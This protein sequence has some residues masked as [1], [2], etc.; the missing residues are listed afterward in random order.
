MPCILSIFWEHCSSFRG[1]FH[2]KQ[3]NPGSGNQSWPPRLP[4]DGDGF[5]FKS[6]FIDIIR[7]GVVWFNPVEIKGPTFYCSQFLLC[8]R[9]ASP[10]GPSRVWI[11]MNAPKSSCLDTWSPVGGLGGMVLLKEVCHCRCAL[12][13][14]KD[15]FH[16]QLT[17]C[18]LLLN[19]DV[20][21]QLFHLP[22]LC[23]GHGL[24]LT[25]WNH[26]PN[27]TLSLT[28]KSC[29]SHGVLLQHKNSN[30]DRSYVFADFLLVPILCEM[31]P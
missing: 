8:S 19:Q 12:K 6:H 25:L 11:R 13:L 17:L 24:Y 23:H 10:F 18:L 15:S 30:Q 29:F 16:S 3:R 20:C 14:S 9:T 5:E 7:W 4:R 26:K 1:S 22:E 2:L 31:W 28:R 27:Q 21:S